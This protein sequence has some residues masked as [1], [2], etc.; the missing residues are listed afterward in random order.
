MYIVHTKLNY[1]LDQVKHLTLLLVCLDPSKFWS[2]HM[3]QVISRTFQVAT[4]ILRPISNALRSGANALQLVQGD[5][6]DPF[7][8][9]LCPFDFLKSKIDKCNKFIS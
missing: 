7:G 4:G 8:H 9:R 5:R 6:L 2:F 1:K 3:H